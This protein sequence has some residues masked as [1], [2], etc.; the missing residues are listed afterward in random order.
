LTKLLGAGAGAR[1]LENTPTAV[2]AFAVSSAK[3]GLW[4]ILAES[5]G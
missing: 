2:W 4:I 3:A 1:R 5:G